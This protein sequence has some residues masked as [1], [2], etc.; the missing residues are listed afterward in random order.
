MRVGEEYQFAVHVRSEPGNSVTVR[1]P[2]IGTRVVT[3]TP[4]CTSDRRTRLALAAEKWNA[5]MGYMYDMVYYMDNAV[6]QDMANQAPTRMLRERLRHVTNTRSDRRSR[7]YAAMHKNEIH[8]QTKVWV[9]Q[10]PED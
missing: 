4:I 10:L 5:W 6:L 3:A 1:V 9:E 8:T 2:H 7:L